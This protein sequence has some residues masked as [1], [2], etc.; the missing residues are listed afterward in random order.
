M[1]N[2]A[3]TQ[4]DPRAFQRLL[5]S[6]P[7]MS[8]VIVADKARGVSQVEYLS[9][10]VE[11]ILGYSPAE[12]MADPHFWI[13]HVHPDD[14]SYVAQVVEKA[15]E[16]DESIEGLEYRF[17]TQD[18]QV[19]WLRTDQ[20]IQERASGRVRIHGVMIDITAAKSHERAL[21]AR[22][23]SMQSI[24]DN[25]CDIIA[26][27]D[28]GLRHLS[29][30]DAVER[31]SGIPSRD[32]V[33]KTH[34]ELGI[35][36]SLAELWEGA[37]RKAFESGRDQS[38]EFG[39]D[40]PESTFWYHTRLVPEADRSG[41]IET[42]LA[43]TH[44]IT[45]VIEEQRALR[46]PAEKLQL[47]VDH[48]PDAIVLFDADSGHFI[49][50]NRN[51]VEMLGYSKEELFEIDPTA[52]F[53]EFQP[54]GRD[55]V[56]AATEALSQA[57]TGESQLFDWTLIDRAGSQILC[58]IRLLRLP[59]SDKN[60]VRGSILDISDRVQ[61]EELRKA[62][63]EQYRRLFE[64]VPIGLYRTAPD[65][66]ILV[67]NRELVRLLGY[68]DAETL[69]ELSASDV[70]PSSTAREEWRRSVESTDEHHVQETRLKR[71]DGSLI[72]VREISRAIRD[73][74][75][76]VLYYEGSMEDITDRKIALEK[77]RLSEERYRS[78]FEGVPVGLY[79]TDPAGRILD[80]NDTLVRMLGYEDK[81]SL[82]GLT[83]QELFGEA[84]EAERWLRDL[85]LN[86]QIGNREL[87][88][89]RGDGTPIWIRTTARL[90]RNKR[91]AIQH[92]EAS[93]EDI[94][95]SVEAR[96]EIAR[97]AA[98][99]TENPDPVLAC[100][101]DGTVTYSN[102]AAQEMMRKFGITR[103][104][105]LLPENH[106]QLVERSGGRDGR[107]EKG[108]R[109]VAD[110]V[111]RWL[112]Y[113]HPKSGLLHLYGQDV[114]EQKRAEERLI[115]HAFHDPLTGLAN[116]ALFLDRLEQAV[117]R[118]RRHP[119]YQFAV[120]FMDLDRFK[121]VNDS[122]GHVVGDEL[123][124]AVGRRLRSC[125]RAVDTVAR[126]GGDEF[127][128]L[129]EEIHGSIDATRV[130][131][132]IHRSLGK[133][134]TISDQ[135]IFTAGSIGIA[136][137]NREYTAGEEVIR[138][139][140]IAMYRAK[141]SHAPYVI[142]D[143]SMHEQAVMA[144]KLETD[145][146]QGLSN[147]EFFLEFQPIVRIPSKE[148]VGFEALLRWHHPKLGIIYPPDFLEMVDESGLSPALT[149]L[150][151]SEA[152]RHAATW[153][154]SLPAMEVPPVS[155]DVTG[156]LALTSEF[157]ESLASRLDALGLNPDQL[158]LEIPEQT[159]IDAA[160]AN[161]MTLR[162]L[163]DLGIRLHV[164]E[165]GAGHSSLRSL[166]TLPID[167]LKIDRSFTAGLEEGS[168]SEEIIQSIN[169]LAESLRI[170]VIASGVETEEQFRRLTQLGPQFAQGNFLHHPI[171]GQAVPELL[172]G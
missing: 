9:P 148:I 135:E 13:E 169:R 86:G 17:L 109:S 106:P 102:P 170:E 28:S 83:A 96:E 78:L 139:S 67:V 71:Y 65:G 142:F 107:I 48:A 98:F 147:G 34:R 122:L 119:H 3:F 26:R 40:G 2:E 154:A 97:L 124:Q 87:K 120:L 108:E 92:I 85:Q 130:A 128:I 105:T 14:R 121:L 137:G 163:K 146:R 70:Q 20:A 117:H 104:E 111:L 1:D 73:P 23:Q 168:I 140:D 89:L 150:M 81:T 159:M 74:F 99:P 112:Y 24:F 5:E 31:I 57:L 134:F 38:I 158:I 44:D 132:R 52:L 66:R 80:L 84:S 136:L 25:A 76:T 116:R 61:A 123:L 68:P 138:D 125:V 51:A 69:Q 144:L 37:L 131:T 171:A 11:T 47:I 8:Y 59:E 114:T 35:E 115:H 94:T 156:T 16:S 21:H 64:T 43:L 77:L 103:V 133:A 58:E 161:Q 19:R 12:W 39:V 62:T 82:V 75:G 93:M 95:E 7:I 4:T 45:A 110:R 145:L 90:I 100:G 164:D 33:G 22:E 162:S 153:N 55:S 88:I 15:E 63:E 127:G 143:R 42:V 29:V 101:L 151:V 165:F 167:A 166:H 91:G 6:L 32:H 72:T 10:Q 49:D 53:P 27:F 56:D 152:C 149:E 79:R 126:L 60:I 18:G 118:A 54:D 36:S 157:I 46:K 129:L 113:P 160:T 41:R 30:N 141:T 155:V 172:Q 50:V